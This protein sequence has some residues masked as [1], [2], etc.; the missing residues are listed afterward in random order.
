MYSQSS[1]VKIQMMS[2]FAV[3][4]FKDLWRESMPTYP[5]LATIL[6]FM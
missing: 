5:A 1:F 6:E 3:L 2:V 4:L